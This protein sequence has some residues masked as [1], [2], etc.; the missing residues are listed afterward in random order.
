M[1]S[2]CV[3][4]TYRLLLL[5]GWLATCKLQIYKS[6]SHTHL[7]TPPHTH[8]SLTIQCDLVTIQY[9]RVITRAYS[10]KVCLGRRDS[11][12]PEWEPH[13]RQ[14]M[15]S[16]FSNPLVRHF[17]ALPLHLPLSWSVSL[18]IHVP[19]GRPWSPFIMPQERMQDL[20]QMY[21]NSLNIPILLSPALPLSL[22]QASLWAMALSVKKVCRVPSL[23]KYLV[24]IMFHWVY[25]SMHSSSAFMT[26][27][28]GNRGTAY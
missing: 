26:C 25:L 28:H 27:R 10:G 11:D 24:T 12:P 17:T 23:G 7:P 9:S 6:I 16:R 20:F 14:C 2:V 1:V 19:K 13:L 18:P 4:W 3:L 15:G 21:G 5:L 8:S 22:P